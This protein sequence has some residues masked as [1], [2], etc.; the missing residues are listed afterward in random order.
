MHP[1]NEYKFY[2]IYK[3][4][5]IVNGKIYVGVHAANNLEN[6]YL[7]SGTNLRKAIKKYGKENFSKEILQIYETYNEALNEERRIVTLEFVKDPK[8]YNLEIGGLGGKVWTKELREKMSIVNKGRIPW[9]KGKHTGNFMS[10]NSRKTLSEKMIGKK[11]HM[12]GI[13][14]N[15]ILSPEKNAERLKKISENNRKPKKT[16]EALCEYAKQRFWIVNQENKLSHC[17][18]KHD[19]RL[20]NGEYQ[21]GRKWKDF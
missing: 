15:K 9:N 13:D 7:G 8:T 17:I 21:L 19:E 6:R 14:V 5:N 3:I 1:V 12:F 18:N 16:T 2:Y 20:L 4:T 11:N 10:E